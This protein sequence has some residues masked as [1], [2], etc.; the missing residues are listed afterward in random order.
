[1]FLNLLRYIL[2]FSVQAYKQ[3]VYETSNRRMK[4]S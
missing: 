2:F 3:K 4:K 1:M